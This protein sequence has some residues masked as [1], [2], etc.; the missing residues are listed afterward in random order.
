MFLPISPAPPS[1][2]TRTRSRV[3]RGD[4]SGSDGCGRSGPRQDALPLQDGAQDVALRPASPRP[5]AGA[6]GRGDEPGHLERRLDEDGARG[7]EEAAIE[8]AQAGV[9]AARLVRVAAARR[10]RPS[11]AISSPTRCEATEMTPAP[12]MLHHREQHVVVAGVDAEARTSRPPGAQLA[13]SGFACFTATTCRDLRQ[14]GD[15]VG[16]HVH[17]RPAR[18][19][20]ERSP[21]RP[22]SAIAA[23]WPTIP[24]RGRAV[25]VGRDHQDGVGAGLGGQVRE[26]HRVG[27]VVAARSRPRRSRGPPPRASRAVEARPSRRR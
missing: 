3:R 18:D 25:V 8:L 15:E 19:V 27:G 1:G 4:C 16:G 20:V 22:T 7:D 24:A 26:V 2:I 14:L 17:R 9:A 21:G 6:A 13:R 23:T 5:A 10:P 12:P 11:P